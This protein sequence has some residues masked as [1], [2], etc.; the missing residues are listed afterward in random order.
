MS[1]L[2]HK[3]KLVLLSAGFVDIVLYI[4]DT[5]LDINSFFASAISRLT[6]MSLWSLGCIL[7]KKKT[8][9]TQQ[10][11]KQHPSTSNLVEP[12]TPFSTQLERAWRTASNETQKKGV[13]SLQ[14]GGQLQRK[15]PTPQHYKYN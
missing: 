9:Q 3:P 12:C 2:V 8:N 4:N 6:S 11:R 14:N 7:L 5:F 1:T 13:E 10:N 15:R